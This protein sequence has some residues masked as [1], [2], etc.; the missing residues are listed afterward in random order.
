M[1]PGTSA[2]KGSGRL[3]LPIVAHRG[4]AAEFPENTLPAIRSAFAHGIPYVE[5]DVQLAADGVPVVIHDPDLQRTGGLAHS[6]FEM[7]A[8]KLV[9]C[10]VH[11]PARFGERFAGTCIPTLDEVV[12][13]LGGMAGV[14]AFVEIKRASIAHHGL[15]RT[16]DVVLRTA[17][18]IRERVVIISYSTEAIARARAQGWRIG[19]VLESYEG[20]TRRRTEALRPEFVFCNFRKLPTD[21]SPLWVG[22]WQWVLYEITSGDVARNLLG[23]G[24]HLLSTMHI[25]ALRDA[26]LNLHAP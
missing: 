23:R 24:A 14:T 3:R 9:S 7:P 17:A 19:V 20:D 18:P 10:S 15:D 1:P 12:G 8:E 22:P 26:L 4:N 16:L 5:F 6:L 25:S 13:A 21:D 2:V 11:E